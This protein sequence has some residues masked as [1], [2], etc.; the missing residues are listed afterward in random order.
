MD[1]FIQYIQQDIRLGFRIIPVCY[2][3]EELG[4]ALG[5]LCIIPLF[6]FY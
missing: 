3:I 5:N 2:F 1:V 4:V 6:A